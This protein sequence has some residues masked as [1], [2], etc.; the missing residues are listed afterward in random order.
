MYGNGR[1]GLIWDAGVGRWGPSVF[2][3]V[4][5]DNQPLGRELAVWLGRASVGL[6]DRVGYTG[7][8]LGQ[9][10]GRRRPGS[11]AGQ[12][13]LAR[14]GRAGWGRAPA[15]G[16]PQ[17]LR[18]AT[19]HWP[20]CLSTSQT[21]LSLD[22]WQSEVWWPRSLVPALSTRGPWL[23][24]LSD[25]RGLPRKRARQTH[26]H[27]RFVRRGQVEG[28]RQGHQGHQQQR[29]RCTSLEAMLWRSRGAPP[30]RPL[31]APALA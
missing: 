2:P 23:E 24:H 10:W 3:R 9:A 1:V 14:A 4:L 20:L 18:R 19:P 5:E 22:S 16:C 27:P 15:A 6:G 12:L 31:R 7:P 25:S 8:L 13:S 21:H 30:L 11:G 17:G 28:L 29:Q 26:S